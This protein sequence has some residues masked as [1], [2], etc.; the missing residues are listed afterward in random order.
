[1]KVSL[2]GGFGEK[3]RT[4]LGVQAQGCRL[5]LDAG[6]KTSARGRDD[7]FPAIADEELRDAAAIVITHA[8]EDHVAALGH[9]IARGFRGR[10]LMTRD[11]LADCASLLRGYGN[12]GDDARLAGAR[13]ETLGVRVDAARVGPFTVH[14]GRSG[15][16]AGGVW[17]AI[18]DGGVRLVYCGDVAAESPVFAMDPLP[19]CDALVMD[20]S[21]GDDDVAFAARA[22][23]IVA[24]VD[25]HRAGC[26]LPT[27]QFGRSLE[28]FALLE[29]RALLAPGMRDALAMQ[30]TQPQWLRADAARLAAWLRAARDYD[31][32]GTVA[33]PI[34]CHDGMGLH[35]PSREL[36][37]RAQQ[38]GCA[39]LLTGHVP[40]DSPG[41]RL[42]AEG[43][44]D[45]IRLPTH[46]TLHENLAFVAAT[47]AAIV[48]GH[49]CGL[50]ELQR[51][52]AHAPQLRAMRTGDNVSLD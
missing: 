49:S 20:A 17:C 14:T 45:W 18:D 40:D 12:A 2:Y 10:V 37:S 16:I 9:F 51:L 34:L 30:L 31:M 52:A 7:Y 5:L 27:P 1:M 29:G 42:L 22:A 43:K 24:W 4:C 13:I 41:H 47:D 38:D 33:A 32:Q 3:G 35:G 39:V 26:V 48:L 8:H 46:P 25:A 21:Y 11:T 44:A 19:R 6:V 23:Q 28:L 15:H 36:L 50:P